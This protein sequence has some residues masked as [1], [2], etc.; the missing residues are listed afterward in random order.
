MFVWLA[1]VGSHTLQLCFPP[2]VHRK[3]KAQRK[4]PPAPPFLS[5]GGQRP[6]QH[7]P[8]NPA[9]VG[10]GEH[11][12]GQLSWEVWTENLLKVKFDLP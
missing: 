4:C 7:H 10:V 12:E 2:G 9:Q 1:E 11:G 6:G 8:H 5:A 3:S